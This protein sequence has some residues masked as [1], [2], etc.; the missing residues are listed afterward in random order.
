VCVCERER[1]GESEREGELAD[2]EQTWS[3]FRTIATV[4]CPFAL[5]FVIYLYYFGVDLIYLITAGLFSLFCNCGLISLLFSC[6]FLR[7]LIRKSM[8]MSA[9][10]LL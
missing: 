7:F 6:L 5:I 10:I 9:L 8:P 4:R 3:T 2:G 1:E